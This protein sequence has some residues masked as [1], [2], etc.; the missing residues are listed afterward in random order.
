VT[1]FI[2]SR[3]LGLEARDPEPIDAGDAL[4][5]Y[6]GTYEREMVRIELKRSGDRLTAHLTPLVRPAGWEAS[7]PRPPLAVGLL[8]DPDAYVILEGASRGTRGRFIRNESGTLEWL[9]WGGRLL[10]RR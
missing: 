4:D 8:E 2:Q 10:R 5:E 7:A 6:A 3:L 9:R 1:R